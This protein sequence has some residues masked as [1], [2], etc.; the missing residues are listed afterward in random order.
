MTKVCHVTCVHGKEDV[1]IFLKECCSLAQAG[2]DVWLVQQGENYDKRGVHIAGF[3][4]IAPNRLRRMLQTA[5]QAYKK[6]L[7]VDAD[8]YHLHDPELLPYALKLKQRG[9]KV[10]FDSHEHTAEAILE[11]N[12]L[13][14]A[15]RSLVYKCFVAYQSYVCRRLDGIVSVTPNIVE[16]FRKINSRTVQIANYPIYQEQ[17]Q[18]PSYQERR[19]VFA[20]GISSQWNHHTIIQSLEKIPD[21]RFC[22]CGVADQGY[23]EKLKSLPGWRQVD[24][25]GK[26]PHQQVAGQ[27]AGCSVGLA[28]LS[29]GRNTD[30]QNGTIGNTKIF[31]EMM[32]ALPVVCTDFVLWKDFVEGYNCGFCV[33]PENVD[34][35]AEKIGYL[36]DHP[37]EAKL[38]GENGRKAV[39]EAFN[40][41]KEESKLFAFYED[42]LKN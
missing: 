11:K 15:V 22:L 19:V 40:W 36:L 20:G 39:Q 33:N 6:A 18:Y 35:V 14:S 9:K 25:L 27:M 17:I 28:L 4:A 1:R 30:W 5:K 12:Y 23:M 29:P 21:C 10:I 24:Y 3:G 37:K 38:M 32:A 31:E 8:L 26:I 16:F 41:E 2:Y 13:P 42:I 7:E 34:A